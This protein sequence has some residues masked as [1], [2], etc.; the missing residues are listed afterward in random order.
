MHLYCSFTL[1]SSDIKKNKFI[2]M[3]YIHSKYHSFINKD[4]RC[5]ESSQKEISFIYQ[6]GTN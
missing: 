4:K 3:I 6:T 1:F 2:H 5:D